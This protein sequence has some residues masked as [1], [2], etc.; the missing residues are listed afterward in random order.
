M[1]DQ[2]CNIS[3]ANC[4][5]KFALST[6]C[7]SGASYQLEAFVITLVGSGP[8][9]LQGGVYSFEGGFIVYMMGLVKGC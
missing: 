3:L 8:P 1:Y 9:G 7:R 2:F 6:C 5:A 4:N